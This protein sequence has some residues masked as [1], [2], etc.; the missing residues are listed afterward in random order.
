LQIVDDAADL[1]FMK[2]KP[3]VAEHLAP[4]GDSEIL[5]AIEA[6]KGAGAAD[7]RPVKIVELDAILAA[8]E[9]FGDDQPIDPDFHARRLPE[10]IWRHTNPTE[11]SANT[12]I[13]PLPGKPAKKLAGKDAEN[14]AANVTDNIEAVIQLHRLREVLA[15]A[16]FTRFEAQM[17]DINGEYETDVERAEIALEPSWFPAVEN[18]GEGIFIQLKPAAIASWLTRPAVKD[19]LDALALGHETWKAA[20]KSKRDFPGGPYIL[21]HTLSHLLMQTLSMR[22][23]YPSSSIHERIYSDAPAQRF[24]L[25]LYTASPDA[26]GTLGGLVQQARHLEDHLTQAL[27]L[28]ELCSNDPICADHKPGESLETR[29]LHGAACHGCALIA[30]TSCEMANE[31]LDRAL[32]IPV[33]GSP[34]AAF[35]PQLQ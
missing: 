12:L 1:N 24:G 3:H 23:G 29:W 11:N 25:L 5:S 33:L 26:E 14:L 35:F 9:G 20:R 19:R 28:S 27:R 10:K 4:Y 6:T 34:N 21:L 18:H 32:V 22:C 16:G 31:Y 17:P 15:L 7:D 8:P 2:K 30:E 13:Y